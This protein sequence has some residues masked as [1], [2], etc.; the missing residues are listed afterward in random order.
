MGLI[1]AST[2]QLSPAVVPALWT[3][4]T[5]GPEKLVVR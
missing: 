5:G 1:A 4:R 2:F 3:W